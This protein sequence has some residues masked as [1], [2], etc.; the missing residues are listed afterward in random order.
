MGEIKIA[1]KN[2]RGTSSARGMSS[3]RGRFNFFPTF[4]YFYLYLYSAYAA[5]YTMF[6][7][8][9]YKAKGAWFRGTSIFRAHD[10]KWS[11]VDWSCGAQLELTF[12]TAEKW[13]AILWYRYFRYGDTQSQC[14]RWYRYFSLISI[15][16]I[17]LKNAFNLNF[18]KCS[19]SSVNIK[20]V[21]FT[22]QV[23]SSQ[24]QEFA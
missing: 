6:T 13:W 7:S 23:E 17:L 14:K 11:L 18:K 20:V 15:T 24:K 22:S 3:A 8:S 4:S 2:A 5:H 19:C 10:V 16:S 21:R 1:K 12:K 9:C